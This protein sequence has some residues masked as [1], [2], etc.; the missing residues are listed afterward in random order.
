M[1][2][3][4]ETKHQ[5]IMNWIK[6]FKGE[7]AISLNTKNSIFSLCFRRLYHQEV[8]GGERQWC[9]KGGQEEEWVDLPKNKTKFAVA[10]CTSHIMEVPTP[11]GLLSGHK[12]ERSSGRC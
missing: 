6:Y 8:D 11:C 10:F 4:W 12:S 9:I 5:P 7:L 3:P 1:P 2:R